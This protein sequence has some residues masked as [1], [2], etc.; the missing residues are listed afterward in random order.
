MSNQT[1]SSLEDLSTGTQLLPVEQVSTALQLEIF[2][3][4]RQS[5]ASGDIVEEEQCRAYAKGF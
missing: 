4:P 1:S 3:A 5:K 2:P